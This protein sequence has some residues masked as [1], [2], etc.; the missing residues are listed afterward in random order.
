MPA[1]TTQLQAEPSTCGTFH[2][3]PQ[4]TYL[5]QNGYLDAP[6]CPPHIMTQQATW[7]HWH[8]PQSRACCTAPAGHNK[9]HYS[10]KNFMRTTTAGETPWSRSL[11]GLACRWQRAYS[12]T[13]LL[14]LNNSCGTSIRVTIPSIPPT[15]LLLGGAQIPF[16]MPK[17]HANWLQTLAEAL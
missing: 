14:L 3:M 7:Q 16:T 9:P 6:G 15:S 8:S 4:R 17:S 13:S 2:M 11:L 5:Y 1:C 12:V 10:M